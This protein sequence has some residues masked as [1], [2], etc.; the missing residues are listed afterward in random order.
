MSNESKPRLLIVDDNPQN[1][2][3]LGN[4]LE[5][6]NYYVEYAQSGKE[7]IEW[8]NTQSFDLILLDIMMPEMDGFEVCEQIRKNTLFDDVP[9]IFLTAKSDKY[10]IVKG[11]EL[12]AQDFIS[13]PFDGA[14][15]IARVKTQVDLKNSK[16]QLKNMNQWLEIKVEEKTSELLKTNQELTKT[17]AELKKLD[18]MKNHFLHL[19]TNEIRTPLNGIIG[20]LHLIKNQEAA[21]TLK[22][23]ID[24]LEKS[25]AR[26]E[27]FANKA[28]LTTELNSGAY[29]VDMEI[30]DLTEIV[31]YCLFEF[32]NELANK[33]LKPLLNST[34][35]TE[36]KADKNLL[37][38]LFRYVIGNAIA[39][40]PENKNIE[41]EIKSDQAG[42]TCSITDY[43]E[44]FVNSDPE[45]IFSPY[46]INEKDYHKT[47]D[48]S[49]Y[50]IKLI[51]ELHNGTVNVFNKGDVGACVEIKFLTK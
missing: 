30:V 5:K 22:D 6:S 50:I 26:I 19:T 1:L 49:M 16:D 7:A 48:M 35:V 31:K 43:G 20:T 24:I 25:V 45:A 39:H 11:L 13:K 8:T 38:K 46:S 42:L 12:N 10:S 3:V 9:I 40:S 37:M 4:L 29:A 17:L 28:I 47:N 27:S 41:I 21:T 44:G 34:T 15:L 14:E 23:L 36:I 51:A 33:N 18:A 32:N 2:Q